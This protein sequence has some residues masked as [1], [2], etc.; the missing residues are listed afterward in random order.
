MMLNELKA[1]L[2][3]STH[4]GQT[5]NQEDCFKEVR[6]LKMPL[7]LIKNKKAPPAASAYTN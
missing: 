4:V 3:P 7:V 6:S 1:V 2:K 5:N